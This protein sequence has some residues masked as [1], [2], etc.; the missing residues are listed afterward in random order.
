MENKW[1]EPEGYDIAPKPIRYRIKDYLTGQVVERK[2]ELMRDYTVGAMF[3]S[4]ASRDQ[5][6][7]DRINEL[8]QRACHYFYKP[9]GEYFPMEGV[10]EVVISDDAVRE[11]I[12]RINKG[13]NL[14]EALRT[15]LNYYDLEELP[16][17]QQRALIEQIEK[18]KKDWEFE[19]L[20]EADE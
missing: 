8:I 13:E 16:F 2:T 7:A 19:I 20:G 5:F 12:R 11:R 4:L 17:K 14:R 9:D 3:H 18:L 6:I 15:Q 1:A 10:F